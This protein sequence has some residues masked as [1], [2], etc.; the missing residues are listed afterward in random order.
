M[1]ENFF[2]RLEHR[3]YIEIKRRKL[4]NKNPS[5]IANNCSGGIIA[6]DLG[7]PFN[8]PLVNMIIYPEDYLKFLKNIRNY[9]DVSLVRIEDDEDGNFVAECDDIKIVFCHTKTYE[10]ALENWERR[11]K[12]FNPDN[13]YVIFCDKMGC[14][15]ENLKE[16]DSLP[17]KH[18]VVFTHKPY[19][20]FKSAYYFRGFEDKD[21]VGVLS[22]WKPGF[23]KRRWLDDF[24]YVSFLNKK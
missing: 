3:I 22:D 4:K 8:S 6:H 1:S 7:L 11:K 21:E 15:Y 20:E 5:I 24:D 13:M 17:L 16:F 14:T 12:R 2:A 10:E 19:P 9:F 18:K 23:L